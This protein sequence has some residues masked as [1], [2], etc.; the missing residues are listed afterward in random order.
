[1]AKKRRLPIEQLRESGRIANEM[2][3]E[4]G[5]IAKE[6]VIDKILADS[7]APKLPGI[8]PY[9]PHEWTL[10]ASQRMMR[11][12]LIIWI[13]TCRREAGDIILD[14]ER[15]NGLPPTRRMN[16]LLRKSEVAYE[17]K[18]E[19][20]TLFWRFVVEELTV[21]EKK[22]EKEE[23][24]MGKTIDSLLERSVKNVP[25]M[26]EIFLPGRKRENTKALLQF[27]VDSFAVGIIV[28]KRDSTSEY[29]NWFLDWTQDLHRY[30]VKPERRAL[31]KR[32]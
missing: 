17:K 27:L 1:M 11:A 12:I 15:E 32:V 8:A 31:M 24:A 21:M 16:I 14:W 7:K 4:R 3:I 13:E 29:L 18:A 20:I 19:N 26:K 23:K 9:L 10:K 2:L 30:W 25:V 22:F 5:I 28:E 6:S